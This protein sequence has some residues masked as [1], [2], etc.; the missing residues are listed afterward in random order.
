MSIRDRAIAWLDR[1]I[2]R[3]DDAPPSRLDLMDGVGYSYYD[4]NTEEGQ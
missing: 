2:P 1:Y 4:D 3:I